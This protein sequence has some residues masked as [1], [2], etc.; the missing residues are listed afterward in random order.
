MSEISGL[1]SWNITHFIKGAERYKQTIA[2]SMDYGKKNPTDLP[3]G[4]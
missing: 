3:A 1:S 4:F 2:F